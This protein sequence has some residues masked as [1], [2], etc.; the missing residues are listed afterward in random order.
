VN[1]LGAGLASFVAALFGAIAGV[2]LRIAAARMGFDLPP[3]VGLVAGIGA[4]LASSE[5]S[6]LR[7]VLVASLAVWAAAIG[8]VLVH[9]RSGLVSDLFRFSDRLGAG[10]LVAYAL[11][12]LI[13][14]LLGSRAARGRELSGDG[15]PRAR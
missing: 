14:F 13:A 3:L 6:G 15:S 10:G 5:R 11:T 4:A 9:P 7:G 2:L 12:G 1:W 8:E